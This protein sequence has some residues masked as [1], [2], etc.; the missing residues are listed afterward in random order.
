[1]NFTDKIYDLDEED[2]DKLLYGFNLDN[3]EKDKKK[4]IINVYHVIVIV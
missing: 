2:I 3:L 1:M 4:K